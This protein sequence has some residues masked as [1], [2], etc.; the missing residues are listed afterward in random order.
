MKLLEY[1]LDLNK[2]LKPLNRDILVRNNRETNGMLNLNEFLKKYHDKE[3]NWLPHERQLLPNEII[4]EKQVF[5]SKTKAEA[6]KIQE[7]LVKKDFKFK[8]FSDKK[9]LYY[10]ITI[11]NFETLEKDLREK[12]R[13]EFYNMFPFPINKNTKAY[14]LDSTFVLLPFAINPD[15]N[16]ENVLIFSVDGN[17][18][19][20]SE[21]VTNAR[22][23]LN[24]EKK[25]DKQ[26][27][28]SEFEFE[29]P[30][31]E[32]LNCM[33]LVLNEELDN[34]V[35]Q[36]FINNFISTNY[37]KEELEKVSN[38]QNVAIDLLKELKKKNNSVPF[39][40]AAVKK[41]LSFL[42][43]T[44]LCFNCPYHQKFFGFEAGV[45]TPVK[46]PY[47]ELKIKNQLEV[48]NP[49]KIYEHVV[50]TI[51]EN[52]LKLKTLYTI[53][54]FGVGVGNQ[55]HYIIA[56]PYE[57]ISN[58]TY[59]K[60]ISEETKQ[61]LEQH[62]MNYET[63]K[64]ISGKTFNEKHTF[65]ENLFN[66]FKLHEKN[67]LLFELTTG[68]DKT[69]LFGLNNK[70]WET[71][72]HDFITMGVNVDPLVKLFFLSDTLIPSPQ[73]IAPDKLMKFNPHEIL[74][75]STKAG[76]STIASRTSFKADRVT[77]S[78]MLG[79][80]DAKN[81]VEGKIKGLNYA[82]RIDE[83]QEDRKGNEKGYLLTV[84]EQGTFNSLVGKGVPPLKTWTSFSF[85]GNPRSEFSEENELLIELITKFDSLLSKITT[86]YQALGSR[87][88]TVM[89]NLETN[90]ITGN[91]FEEEQENQL[92]ALINGLRE[93]TKI[94]FTYL[95][96]KKQVLEFLQTE[97]S[98]DYKKKMI[99]LIK[100]SNLY[101]VKEFMMG[102][103]ESYKHLNGKA[104]KTSLTHYLG[105]LVTGKLDLN[106]VIKTA[107]KYREKFLQINIDS[108][109]KIV[110]SISTESIIN[111]ARIKYEELPN[112]FKIII[113]SALTLQ[114][115]KTEYYYEEIKKEIGKH[116][117]TKEASSRVWL[118]A[119]Q[120]AYKHELTLHHL[121]VKID[122]NITTKKITI[123]NPNTLRKIVGDKE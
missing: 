11:K 57:V 49:K 91:G 3:V 110:D 53:W 33:Q 36:V 13:Q 15:N 56:S 94:P 2:F 22:K 76:K 96:K 118:K 27:H 67:L 86:N 43:K 20:P 99:K 18:S 35:K 83:L 65:E 16:E 109:E 46:T 97:Y 62:P 17:A 117:Y 82:F 4:I 93:Y 59:L 101:S 37:S 111:I 34:S 19:I 105:D 104:F 40:C 115:D 123:L 69:D 100:K 108:F 90:K 39:S 77:I 5:D 32:D 50:K 81:I 92:K 112:Y 122:D 23:K 8:I 95:Y 71:I 72:V 38:T 116:P 31:V 61:L 41:E 114:E 52:S 106:K 75:T 30:R 63:L 12:I 48:V 24:D 121:Q 88:G 26:L 85:M 9:N 87:V 70:D 47:G 78:G 28:F 98:K 84:M 120:N 89:F 79:F 51:E 103:L 14:Y 60:P 29:H 119:T 54:E 44:S 64:K 113:E 68:V 25:K 107:E 7:I 42:N 80:S 58:N 102:H 45:L 73:H 6:D 74:F 55:K 10:Y 21:I 1:L 66:F